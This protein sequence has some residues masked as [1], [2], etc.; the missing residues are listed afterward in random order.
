MEVSGQVHGPAALLAEKKDPVS[1][2]I[3]S[4]VDFRAGLEEVVKGNIKL[5]LPGIELRS[6]SP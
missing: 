5:L 6:S 4:W 2:C 1:H 3:G